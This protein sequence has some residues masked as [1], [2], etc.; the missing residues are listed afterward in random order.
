MVYVKAHTDVGSKGI[1]LR[2]D[3][4]LESYWVNV[5]MSEIRKNRKHLFLLNSD[6]ENTSSDSSDDNGLPLGSYYS[7]EGNST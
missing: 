1:V 5:G 3:K 2:K 7:K 4:S 6:D